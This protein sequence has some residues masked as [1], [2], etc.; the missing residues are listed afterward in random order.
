MFRKI[1]PETKQKFLEAATR[2]GDLV[3][4]GVEG[5]EAIKQAALE[6]DLSSEFVKRLVEPLNITNTLRKIKS[7][8][9]LE[10]AL[11]V[12]PL[13]DSSDLVTQYEE[14]KRAN[15]EE[16]R[17]MAKVA[18]EENFYSK[19]V[20]NFMPEKP[21][22]PLSEVLGVDRAP[23]EKS[24]ASENSYYT[25]ELESRF[26]RLAKQAEQVGSQLRTTVWDLHTNMLKACK[27]LE[28][29][30]APSFDRVETEFLATYES[31]AQ[32]YFDKLAEYFEPDSRGHYPRRMTLHPTNTEPYKTLEEG[33]QLSRQIRRL[34]RKQGVVEAE[35]EKVANEIIDT[36]PNGQK[37]I[38]EK[39]VN[40]TKG[41]GSPPRPAVQQVDSFLQQGGFDPSNFSDQEKLNIF[42]QVRQDIESKR[43]E[44]E[45]ELL[46]KSREEALPIAP[47]TPE[48]LELTP[49]DLMKR[50]KVTKRIPE[51]VLTRELPYRDKPIR[52]YSRRAIQS[53]PKEEKLRRLKGEE[54]LEDK[55][56]A[57]RRFAGL[58]S[59]GTLYELL[60]KGIETAAFGDPDTE[61]FREEL[62]KEM[63]LSDV[64]TAKHEYELDRAKALSMLTELMTT[65]PIIS[66]HDPEDVVEAY[67][68][69]VNIVPQIVDNPVLAR[70]QI[71]ELLE[72]Q[73]TLEPARI[74]ELLE[75]S[76]KLEDRSKR[77]RLP[78]SRREKEKE[79][80]FSEQFS[81]L[82]R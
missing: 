67:N 14:E 77:R 73:R 71:R 38:V 56:R 18:R 9:S 5:G 17:K 29:P 49:Q 51:P 60:G 75:R 34:A 74:L 7:A 52:R 33:V 46:E 64:F 26:E 23:L 58:L 80:W 8:S 6:F 30:N 62:K 66:R 47:G 28:R 45:A 27:E 32:P 31:E 69:L 11:E 78:R 55:L 20:E 43:R 4:S 81:R 21:K 1:T 65:D 72:R 54:T 19:P 22:A 57:G 12:T 35:Q 25:S 24:A 79:E 2:V 39:Y 16:E 68:E 44:M 36:T 13:L 63:E 41:A 59:G 15:R 76:Q 3:S 10:E 48:E 50:M 53:A 37:E 40:F 61:R 70:S 82:Y 42:R